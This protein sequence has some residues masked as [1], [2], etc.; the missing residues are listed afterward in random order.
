M[1]IVKEIINDMKGLSKVNDLEKVTEISL[2]YFFLEVLKLE[3]SLVVVE[4]ETY[5]RIGNGYDCDDYVNIYRNEYLFIKKDLLKEFVRKYNQCISKTFYGY[6][7]VLS[8]ELK[9]K[10]EELSSFKLRYFVESDNPGQELQTVSIFKNKRFALVSKSMDYPEK[11]LNNICLKVIQTITNEL[12]ERYKA[13]IDS[14][15][16][17]RIKLINGDNLSNQD[18]ELINSL[19]DEKEKEIKKENGS[20]L[21]R[22][23]ENK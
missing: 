1:D 15:D 16:S 10:L 12:Y 22:S 19:I 17:V 6:K 4:V 18:I 7:T 14:Y 23:L 9:E 3:P 2:P 5:K 20:I 11:R 8:Y 13:L 21:K